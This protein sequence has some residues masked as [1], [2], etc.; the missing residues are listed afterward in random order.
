VNLCALAMDLELKPTLGAFHGIELFLEF[1][2]D[3]LELFFWIHC[4]QNR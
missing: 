2:L 1:D 4:R 3:T